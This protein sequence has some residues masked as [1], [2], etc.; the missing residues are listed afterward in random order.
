[1]YTICV[2]DALRGRSLS[3]P[4]SELKVQFSSVR[5]FV[6]LIKYLHT[7]LCMYT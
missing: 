5:V 3:R 7:D 1:M 2:F 6:Y 4:C